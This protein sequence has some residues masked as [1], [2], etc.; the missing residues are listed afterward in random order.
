[1]TTGDE[2]AE[3][4]EPPAA[5]GDRRGGLR[6]V[7]RVITGIE[8]G[9]GAVAA[10]LV[11]L[12]VLTQALQR[13]LPVEGWSW[14]GELAR[15]CL[16]WLTFTVAGVLVTS[17]SHISLQLVDNVG[18]RTVVR[19]VRVI[20]SLIVA[21]I[22]VG[23]AA[24]AISLIESQDLIKS[25]A[26]QMPISWLYVLPLLGFVSTAVR[27]LVAAVDFAL[28]GVPEAHPEEVRGA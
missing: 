8:L 7:V 4:R 2:A 11:F 27:G 23:F 19:A 1:V 24:E 15:F 26:M 17:D 20:A 6:R 12:L 22:G 28:H 25:P 13:Y 21:A 5:A 16:V 3:R 14:T 18:N 9:I 10:A